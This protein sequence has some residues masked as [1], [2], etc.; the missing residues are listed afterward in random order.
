MEDRQEKTTGNGPPS[1]QQTATSPTARGGAI[2]YMAPL[3]I[4]IFTV[5]AF[6]PALQNGFVNWD[7][8]MTL[9]THARYRGFDWE[10]LQWMF[11]TFYMGHYQPLTWLTFG[12]DHFLWGL[13]PFGF[14]L[15]NIVLH[16]INAVLFYY[17][18][19]RLLA[20][21]A[22]KVPVTN[23][24]ALTAAACISALLF[25]VHPLRVESVV[26]A[27]QRRD[28]LC[29]F[30]LLVTIL[31]YVKATSTPRRGAAYRKWMTA[32]LSV[33]TLSL[34][35]KAAGITLPLVLLVLDVYPLRRLAYDPAK[36]LEREKRQVFWEKV[37]FVL[38]AMI[39][40][41]IALIAQR[42]GAAL[43]SLQQHGIPA[44][45]AQAFFGIV[46]YLWKSIV[47]LNLSPLYELAAQ[48]D[49]LDGSFV[50]SAVVVVAVTLG[51]VAMRRRWP[52]GLAVWLVYVAIL[53]P[54]LGAAQSGP[55]IAADRYT[56]L[57]C[58]GWALLVGAALLH[59]RPRPIATIASGARF[60]VMAAAASALLA[61]LGA[62]TWRQAQVWHDSER[63]WK[64]AVAATPHSASAH[65]NLGFVFSQRGEIDA[66]EEQYR[67]SIEINPAPDAHNNLGL[68]LVRRGKLD[69]ATEHYR[70]ALRINPLHKN[71]YSNLAAVS[72]R[73]ENLEEA[74]DYYRRVLQI[75]PADGDAHYQ[76]G[77]ILAKRGDNAGSAKHY[78]E[79]A[80]TNPRDVAS[81][82]RLAEILVQRRDI[83]GAIEQLRE[84]LRL[85]PGESDLHFKL[86]ILLAL[87]GQLGEAE[88]QFQQALRSGP[89][90]AEAH[91]NLGRIKAA[92]GE[93][94]QA[95]DQFREAIRIQPD[96]AT[97]HESLAMALAEQ[98]KKDEA[99]KHY[100][101]AIRLLKT[102]SKAARSG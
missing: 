45:L 37:P 5:L 26:W 77:E 24:V 11:T 4:F 43:K 17:A 78:Q 39:F 47:P 69:E 72:L 46:F 19:V 48:V 61:S 41:I 30:F 99:A 81:R 83:K 34:F 95:I 44:R 67:R 96:Y 56:Y 29:A 55:Q 2:V 92:R 27:S 75:D 10:A 94:K 73:R 38:L 14:H 79:A 86:G 87:Q 57:A 90:F 20:L 3:A 101:E 85:S 54:V 51:L 13:D 1:E 42:D 59:W 82:V 8:E 50:L 52:A 62:L 31:V 98:G 91:H 12:L 9:V 25:A 97:A 15:T 66:A 40:G 49:P 6:L 80:R 76:L 23:K 89:D 33:Y 88:E 16:G 74:M 60:A 70:E 84:A 7:D 18:S 35:S 22:P 93:L 64:H 68:I 28:V 65:Y 36:W 71:A 58:L 100:Q 21:S 63:L 53:M 102:R 32:A